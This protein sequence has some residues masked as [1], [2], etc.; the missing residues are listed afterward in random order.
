MTWDEPMDC[1]LPTAFLEQLS[2]IFTE[3]VFRAKV[4]EELMAGS[5]CEAFYKGD[6]GL[7][8]V[9]IT[10]CVHA[11]VVCNSLPNGRRTCQVLRSVPV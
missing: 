7:R 4:T 3:C 9:Q 5:S 6:G 2:L 8:P 11:Y 1:S 10:L